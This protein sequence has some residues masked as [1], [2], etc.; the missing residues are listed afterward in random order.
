LILSISQPLITPCVDQDL[1]DL[2]VKLRQF[3]C[4]G[5][6]LMLISASFLEETLIQRLVGRIKDAIKYLM[7]VAGIRQ[8]GQLW[9]WMRFRDEYRK[10]MRKAGFL[11]IIDDFLET[12]HQ[13]TYWIKGRIHE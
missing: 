10:V 8:R 1:V 13:R 3:L 11:S 12:N 9:G 2:L 7:Y 4:A 5:G 6:E